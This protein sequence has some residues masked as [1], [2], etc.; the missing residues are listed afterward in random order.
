MSCFYSV[1]SAISSLLP[2]RLRKGTT[3]GAHQL[4][5]TRI[6]RYQD[7]EMWANLIANESSAHLQRMLMSLMSYI[8]LS[9]V[10]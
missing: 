9:T 4:T 1:S 7:L 10:L 6:V 3:S 2:I 8:P 5:H